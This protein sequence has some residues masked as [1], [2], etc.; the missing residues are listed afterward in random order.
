MSRA[1]EWETKE[2][3]RE[4]K[5]GERCVKGEELREAEL[6]KKRKDRTGFTSVPDEVKWVRLLSIYLL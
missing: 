1:E 6:E 5:G 3:S 4:R 2:M